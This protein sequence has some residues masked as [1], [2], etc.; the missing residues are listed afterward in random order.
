[1]MIFAMASKSEIG[2]REHRGF[3]GFGSYFA[4][5]IILASD[6]SVALRRLKHQ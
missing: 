3:V 5:Q 1:M 6:N 2:E 4:P